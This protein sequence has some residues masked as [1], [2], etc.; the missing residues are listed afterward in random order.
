[1]YWPTVGDLKKAHVVIM[2]ASNQSG[3]LIGAKREVLESALQAPFHTFDGVEFYPT[4]VAKIVRLTDGI[5]RAQ[6][7]SDGN[8][9]LAFAT[10][11][12]LLHSRG[13]NLKAPAQQAD[14]WMRYELRTDSPEDL[15]SSVAWVEQRLVP[16]T[17]GIPPQSG[18]ERC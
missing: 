16:V 3:H 5:S 10:L 17:R 15:R 12:T 2:A 6:A 13:W 1:M 7:F 4:D 14:R 8:K 11:T 9:R 18:P